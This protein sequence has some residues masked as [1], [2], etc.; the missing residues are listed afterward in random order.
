MARVVGPA[1]IGRVDEGH[2]ILATAADWAEADRLRALERYAILDTAPE[3]AFDDIV[4]IAA[5]ICGAPA[6]AIS[7]VEA[8]RQWFKAGVGL[9][10]TETPRN[11]SFCTH[12]I[13]VG[14]LYVVRDA[15]ADPLFRDNPLVAGD[16]GLRF[17][18][19]AVLET[20]DGFRLGTVCVVDVAARPQGLTP[21]QGEAL[22]ALARQVVSQLELRRAVS[23][24]Q[25]AASALRLALEDRQRQ[26]ETLRATEERLRFATRAGLVGSWDW[27]IVADRIYADEGFAEA[28][29][30]DSS[31]AGRGAPVAAYLAG[32]HPDDRGWVAEAIQRA[33]SDGGEFGEEYRLAP[34]NGDVRWLFARGRCFRDEDGR[35][36][37]FPGVAIDVTERRRAEEALREANASR[38]LALQAARLGRWDEDP[39]TGRRQWDARTLELFGYAPGDAPASNSLLEAVHPDDR[40]RVSEGIA[41]AMSPDRVGAYSEEFRILRRDTGEIRWLSALGRTAFENGVCVRF[42]GVFQD[43][44]E[45]KLAEQ[46]RQE[47]ELRVRMAV[48]AGA[49]GLWQYRPATGRVTRDEHARELFGA[50]PEPE[51]DLAAHLANVHPDDR[52]RVQN[53]MREA[54]ETL[55]QDGFEVEFRTTGSVDGFPRWLEAAGQ[56][57]RRSEGE[58][59]VL[60]AVRDITGQKRSEEH[61]RLLTNELNHR[62]KN[63]LA[64][65]QGLVLQA[66]RVTPSPEAAMEAISG[67]LAAL[68]RAHDILTRTSWSSAL[69]SDVVASATAPLAGS[70]R[71]LGGGPPIQLRPKAA[72]SL[73]MALYELGVNAVKYGA[74][75]A[76]GGRVDVTWRIED[77]AGERRFRLWW[78]ERGG[79][80]VV[81][82]QRRG[83]GSRLL[84]SSLAAELGGG[85]TL[86]F[87]PS[88]LIW[89]VD[90]PAHAVE[91]R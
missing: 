83:F 89:S 57:F 3:A 37:R 69:M 14:G 32:I 33:V 36:A 26:A 2:S 63:T 56:V 46:A 10:I 65:V 4:R 55:R 91:E 22:Q 59:L 70:E 38:E 18:A 1:Q 80:P 17:Y 51:A 25:G 73:A 88:G 48:R 21:E 53:V 34:R 79:P 43:I 45:R 19:G 49:I 30:V 74:L 86:E 28:F 71:V 84:E 35:P 61:H 16:P 78:R 9:G 62:V 72:L 67:R 66:L 31:L 58:V 12:A 76:E 40:A 42:V 6:A 7:L 64:V 85:A 5:Q 82:P 23:A 81:P 50:G 27:D 90:A 47:A 75:S 44:T 77:S 24:E 41:R 87:H 20:A 8:E 68:G 60:G 11:I 15:A 13:Q 29:G 54:L 52:E 39:T